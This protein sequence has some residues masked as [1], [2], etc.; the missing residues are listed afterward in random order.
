MIGRDPTPLL[1]VVQQA[2]DVVVGEAIAALQ[3]VELDGKGHAG[4][5]SAQLLDQ[6]DGGLHGASGGQ[7]VVYQHHTLAGGDGVK[8]NL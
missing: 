3:E 7:Q 4:D 6:L 8:M 1:V 5:L 2:E